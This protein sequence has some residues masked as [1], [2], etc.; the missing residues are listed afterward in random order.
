MDKQ[1]RIPARRA[2]LIG[3][4]LAG[5]A[6][7]ALVAEVSAAAMLMAG[8]SVAVGTNDPSEKYCKTFKR[9]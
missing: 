6:T 9:V 5:F 3:L 2:G 4:I 1:R 8:A 7:V